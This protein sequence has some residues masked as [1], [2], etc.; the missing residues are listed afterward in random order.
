MGLQQ[1]LGGKYVLGIPF[2]SSA[3]MDKGQVERAD[4]AVSQPKTFYKGTNSTVHVHVELSHHLLKHVALPITEN[5]NE[6]H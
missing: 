5:L 3:R 2:A 4:I 6:S 1:D